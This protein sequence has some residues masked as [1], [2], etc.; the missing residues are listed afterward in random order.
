MR[1]IICA[2]LTCLALPASAE[3]FLSGSVTI[4]PGPLV[5]YTYSYTID[6]TNG[7]A[8]IAD[9]AVLTAF[10]SETDFLVVPPSAPLSFTSPAGWD[11]EESAGGTPSDPLFGGFYEWHTSVQGLSRIEGVQVGAIL[12]GFS[13]T[14]HAPPFEFSQYNYFL[15]GSPELYGNVVA[16][17]MSAVPEPTT[18]AMML[19]G[20]AGIGFMAYRRKKMFLAV[21]NQV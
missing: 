5:T 7:T 2:V 4:N 8:P 18:W 11:F 12:G 17:D 16:P 21:K 3:A 19:L 14:V 9:F 20:F 15:T 6:N 13:V 10:P 1:W